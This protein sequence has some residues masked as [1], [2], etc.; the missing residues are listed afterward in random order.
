PA[1][2][3][4]LP[5]RKT[6]LLIVTL[7]APALV[8]GCGRSPT[9]DSPVVADTNPYA[10]PDLPQPDLPGLHNVHCVAD[11]LYSGSV[12]EGDAGFASLRRLGVQTAISVDGARPDVDR[13]RRFGL[14]YVHIP[15][16][17]DGVP[18]PQ[19]LRPAD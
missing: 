3:G 19:A 17:Y 16:G 18:E 8:A 13:A 9:P 14:R 11:R 7:A 12:P 10:V 15:V 1:A 2:A 5:M 4:R 6:S